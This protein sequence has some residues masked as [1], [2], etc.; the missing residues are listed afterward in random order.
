MLIPANVDDLNAVWRSFFFSIIGI[1]SVFK[2]SLSVL[3][4]EFNL[5]FVVS[6]LYVLHGNC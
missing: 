2:N 5:N 1:K 3:S 4:S 6:W